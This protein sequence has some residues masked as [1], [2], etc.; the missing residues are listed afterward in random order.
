VRRL[1]LP[2]VNDLEM[3]EK[4]KKVL[5]MTRDNTRRVLNDKDIVRAMK[6]KYPTIETRL[7]AM[8]KLP[9]LEQ[10]KEVMNTT[11]LVGMHGAGIANMVWLHKSAALCELFPYSVMRPVYKTIAEKIMEVRYI[12]WHNS[13]K[14]A[15][16]FHPEVLEPFKLA[17]EK[18]DEI[19]AASSTMYQ[20]MAANT[21]WLTQDTRVNVMQ[22][23]DLI[24]SALSSEDEEQKEEL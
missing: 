24:G 22:L 20:S 15:T 5:I 4:Q 17:P 8:H 9:F 12:S 19:M 18:K 13:A 2:K 21:Y 7:I 10:V 1:E 16:V 23:V 11:V 6:T 14:P 3:W